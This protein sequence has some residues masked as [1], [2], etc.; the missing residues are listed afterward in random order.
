MGVLVKRVGT[1]CTFCLEDLPF[2]AW[3]EDD[4]PVYAILT[5]C[6][7]CNQ[8][9]VAHADPEVNVPLDTD[10]V[11]DNLEFF[12]SR[13]A[14]ALAFMIIWRPLFND[15]DLAGDPRLVREV[16]WRMTEDTVGTDVLVTVEGP[17]AWVTVGL[18]YDDASAKVTRLLVVS[19]T[20]KQE[21]PIEVCLDAAVPEVETWTLGQVLNGRLSRVKIAEI[22]G[23][24]DE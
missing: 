24:V 19:K 3:G 17:K 20:K 10:I 16:A 13:S 7:K 2:M 11:A 12:E 4:R 5:Y 15:P 1:K 6:D 8:G 21:G 18:G 23:G 14:L 22:L 9:H